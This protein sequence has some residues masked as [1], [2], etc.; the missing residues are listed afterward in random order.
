MDAKSY[1][2]TVRREVTGWKANLYDVL[3]KAEKLPAKQ[4]SKAAP[5][6]AQLNALIDDLEAK[7]AV[8]ERECPADYSSQRT[9]IQDK[10]SQGKTAWKEVWGVMGEPEYGIGG[11]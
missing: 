2:D 9:A 4:K 3:H 6:V 10:L 5:M 7:L 1:C 8:L 11:P